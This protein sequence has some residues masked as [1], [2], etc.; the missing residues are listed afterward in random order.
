MK[1][2]VPKVLCEV[3]FKPMIGWVL[4]AVEESNIKDV[5]VVTGYKSNILKDFLAQN[6]YITETVLQNSRKG[7]AHAVMEAKTFWDKFT[8]G[9]ILIMGG[10]S[11]FVDKETLIGAYRRHIRNRNSATVISSVTHNPYGYGRI[12]RD[13]SG[14]VSAIVEER[15]ASRDQRE[16][17][18]VNSGIYWFSVKNLAEALWDVTNNTTQKEYYLTS[19]IEILIKK[20]CRVEIFRSASNE[21]ILGAND[22]EQL[23]L[24]NEIARRNVLRNFLKAG[25][26]IPFA[27]GVVIGKDVK[28]GSGTTIYPGTILR[29]LTSVGKNC[30]IGPYCEVIDGTIEDGREIKAGFYRGVF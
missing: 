23:K 19:V 11:P 3:L 2:N 22:C 30:V 5:C 7:T 10:D 14:K 6:G 18:E 28:I 29:G 8:G 17:N 26:N 24:L 20:H 4:D 12:I 25:V 15:E 1:S 13:M 9:D 16:I 21:I 27:D